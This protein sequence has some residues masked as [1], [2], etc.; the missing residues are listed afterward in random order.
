[1]FL[2]NY[3]IYDA[4]LVCFSCLPL[5]INVINCMRNPTEAH[6]LLLWLGLKCLGLT[7]FELMSNLAFGLGLGLAF[8]Y[9]TLSLSL[10]NQEHGIGLLDVLPE[11][12]LSYTC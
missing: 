11:I 6:T 3:T 9:S 1:M 7:S 10:L 2:I 5:E 4:I 8:P 12:C